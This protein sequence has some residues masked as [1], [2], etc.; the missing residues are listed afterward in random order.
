MK[1]RI[2]PDIQLR[3]LKCSECGEWVEDE[4]ATGSESLRGFGSAAIKHLQEE[5]PEVYRDCLLEPDRIELA[6][7]IFTER[8]FEVVED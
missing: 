5:H 7:Y 2:N 3:I 6:F 8:R 4:G 1:L